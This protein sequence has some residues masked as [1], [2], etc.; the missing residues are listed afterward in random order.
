MV[1]GFS[2]SRIVSELC[3][4]MRRK[5]EEMRCV[6]GSLV[7]AEHTHGHK[8][9][10]AVRVAALAIGPGGHAWN[11]QRRGIGCGDGITGQGYVRG[12]S[13]GKQGQ[14][15]EESFHCGKGESRAS[16]P[17]VSLIGIVGCRGFRE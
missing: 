11:R 7:G 6:A 17:R 8:D 3:A 15:R 4:V 12:H 9:R 5:V 10:S 13:K 16:Q 2:D 14:K 1:Q